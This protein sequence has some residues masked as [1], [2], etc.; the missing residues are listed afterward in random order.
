MWTEDNLKTEQILNDDVQMI[1]LFALLKLIVLK[2]RLKMTAN[3]YVF[4]V[5]LLTGSI[6]TVERL[7]LCFRCVIC[8]NI[9]FAN[10]TLPDKKVR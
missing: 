10:P 6:M 5:A 9:L 2:Q 8:A 3:Y 4:F 1:L 7:G